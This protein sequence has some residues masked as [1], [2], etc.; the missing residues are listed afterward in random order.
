MVFEWQ[1]RGATK[2]YQIVSV[3]V[4][5]RVSVGGWWLLLFTKLSLCAS[6][7][8]ASLGLLVLQLDGRGN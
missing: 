2:V 6:V 1:T 4:S 3:G 7:Y 8:S 5:V